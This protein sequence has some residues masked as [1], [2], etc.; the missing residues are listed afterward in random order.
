MPPTSDVQTYWYPKIK[1][2]PV[3]RRKH[4]FHTMSDLMIYLIYGNN[5]S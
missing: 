1:S 4:I 5:V 3:Q 2:L